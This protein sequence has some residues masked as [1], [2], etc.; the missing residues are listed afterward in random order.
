MGAL[1]L[2]IGE[3]GHVLAAGM[4]AALAIWTGR[5]L[6]T[7]RLGKLLVIALSLTAIWALAIAFGGIGRLQTGMMESLRN[8]GWLVCLT[9]FPMQKG[10]GQTRRT[11]PL[12]VVLALLLPAQGALDIIGSLYP[13]SGPVMRSVEQSGIVL[14]ILW[15]IGA[16]ILTQRV[17]RASHRALWPVNMAPLA[18]ALTAMWGYDLM[19]YAS[20][21]LAGGAVMPSLFAFRG[22]ALAATAPVIALM[23]RSRQ[24]QTVQPSR[25]L[26]WYGVWAL[27]GLALVFALLALLLLVEIIPSPI[28]R[29]GVTGALF[30]AVAGALLLLPSTR[31]SARLKLQLAKHLFRHRYDYRE[32]W[33]AF[34]D[35]IG[36]AGPATAPLYD[37]L[38]KAMADITASSG[39]VLLMLDDDR[40]FACQGTWNW[41][42][43]EPE[44]FA[45]DPALLDRMRTH[46]WVADIGQMRLDRDAALPEWMMRCDLCW[47]MVPLLHFGELQGV[48]LLGRPPVARVLD[49][50]DFDMLRA[51]GRQVASYIAEAR[52][53]QAL[54]EA[55]RFEEFNR[56]FA[57]IMHDIKNLVSQ[58]A[59]V[60]R[61]A[62]RHAE[63]PEFR[64]DM[65]L[66]LTECTDKMNMLL[67]RLSQHSVRGE[68][69]RS[70]F[71]LGDAV[72]AALAARRKGHPLVIEGDLSVPVE[73]ERHAV[74]QIIA[75]LV[76]NAIEASAGDAPVIIRVEQAGDTARLSVIDH[77]CGM[78]AEF[79]RDQLYR[80]FVSTKQ[81]G[82]GIGAFEAR[83]LAHALGGHLKAR[84][85]PGK[86]SVFTLHLPVAHQPAAH[87]PA[88]TLSGMERMAR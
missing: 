53:H 17:Y 11:W 7:E 57:F 86:G 87:Q 51:A 13:L 42:G 25:A 43:E 38:L 73:V 49:W 83:E 63:N 47:A 3:W 8:C 4:F 41:Q 56:R 40:R 68:A 50:E 48:I 84:S 52:G 22:G 85:V 77:G 59:L 60:S 64:K 10:M 58:I 18:A 72:R 74:E 75:H 35:T 78:T 81:G 88:A 70:L 80:P 9:L 29:A 32:Q 26:T 44:G 69:G 82:F 36:S 66:T 39:A 20:G 46:A 28:V 65:I 5:R 19:L 12:F 61:N 2:Y 16:L 27:G 14:H 55:R 37:R 21:L 6:A 45:A 31:I 15:A 33:M 30:A 62:E 67:A 34:V 54:E 1:I 23:L 71:A 24:S 79:L 76:Q